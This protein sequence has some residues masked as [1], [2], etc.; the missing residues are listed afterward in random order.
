MNKIF[1][2]FTISITTQTVFAKSPMACF[3]VE[4]MTCAS[5][6]ITTKVAIKKLDGIKG[7]K[8]SFDDKKAEVRYDDAK[9]SS[10]QIRM[11]I[12]SVGYRAI[13]IL[14]SES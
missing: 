1:L 11:K 2:F 8:V 10:D 7:I 4:G 13:Q 9:T 6:A 5:C 3:N 12:D 14:C